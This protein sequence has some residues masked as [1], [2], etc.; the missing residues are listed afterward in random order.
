MLAIIITLCARRQNFNSYLKSAPSCPGINWALMPAVICTLVRAL[1]AL[2][3]HKGLLS[4]FTWFRPKNSGFELLLS[5]IIKQTFRL[6]RMCRQQNYS[7]SLVWLDLLSWMGTSQSS[8]YLSKSKSLPSLMVNV[9]FFLLS[10]SFTLKTSTMLPSLSLRL[11]TELP[12][13]SKTTSSEMPIHLPLLGVFGGFYPRL[14]LEIRFR[15]WRCGCLL[16]LKLPVYNSI[17]WW[18][19]CFCILVLAYLSHSLP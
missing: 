9:Y 12:T 7:I 4:W 10:C 6:I 17:L 16:W 13:Y 11:L 14:W 18:Q 19:W 8:E 3:I 15:C 5:E 1:T 2:C